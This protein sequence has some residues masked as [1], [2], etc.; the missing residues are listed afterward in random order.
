M[1]ARISLHLHYYLLNQTTN[2]VGQWDKYWQEV[3]EL[4]TKIVLRL[5][6][7]GDESECITE[8]LRRLLAEARNNVVVSYGVQLPDNGLNLPSR[9]TWQRTSHLPTRKSGE[10]RFDLM[11][12]RLADPELTCGPTA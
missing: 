5:Q 6:V 10:T 9:L 4:R 1:L 2:F 7:Q 12:V 8:D 3:S 11:E